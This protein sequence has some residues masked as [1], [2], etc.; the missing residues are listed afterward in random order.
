MADAFRQV[1]IHGY[2]EGVRQWTACRG[3]G[4]LIPVIFATPTLPVAVDGSGGG[5]Q[6]QTESL[7]VTYQC[8]ASVR[9]INSL[10]FPPRSE[11]S[12]RVWIIATRF[13]AGEPVTGPFR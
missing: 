3:T 10:T 5:S 4:P 2:T 1:M 13:L 8:G 9:G 6:K 11:R 12:I 7:T